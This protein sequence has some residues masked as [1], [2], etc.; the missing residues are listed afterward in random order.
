MK[1]LNEMGR[2]GQRKDYSQERGNPTSE[3]Q[4]NYQRLMA[5]ED[6]EELVKAAIEIVRPLVGRG[7]S[8]NRYKKFALTLQRTSQ[9]GLDA[10]QRYLTNFLLAGSGMS[11]ESR[12]NAIASLITESTNELVELTP[13]QRVLKEMVERYGY[14]VA[15]RR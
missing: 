10:V 15:I 6:P 1:S 12:E 5:I 7:F 11:T 14:H 3:I 9:E 2:W 13:R 8:E 4:A